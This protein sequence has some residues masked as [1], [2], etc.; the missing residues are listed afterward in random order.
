MV[1]ILKFIDQ[2][3]FHCGPLAKKSCLP[4]LYTCAIVHKYADRK[5]AFKS[6]IALFKMLVKLTPLVS[7]YMWLGDRLS[8]KVAPFKRQHVSLHQFT[9]LLEQ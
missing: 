8:I 9:S 4:P 1:F 6:F 3:C 7:D 5:A 2:I